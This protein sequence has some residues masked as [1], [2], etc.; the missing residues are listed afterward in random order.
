MAGH[1]GC[2]TEARLGALI[3]GSTA[4]LEVGRAFRVL[5]K[6]GL[7]GGVIRVI[8]LVLQVDDV[9]QTCLGDGAAR[10]PHKLTAVAHRVKWTANRLD[11]EY[12]RCVAHIGRAPFVRPLTKPWMRSDELHSSPLLNL[13]AGND[14]PSRRLSGHSFTWSDR[15]GCMPGRQAGARAALSID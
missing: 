9:V 2:R 11:Y 8:E 12:C 13:R 5:T 7:P 15:R 3:D 1:T 10:N 4:R 14:L 6:A